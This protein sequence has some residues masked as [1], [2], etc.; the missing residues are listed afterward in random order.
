MKLPTKMEDH[1]HVRALSPI[2]IYFW[3]E[4]EQ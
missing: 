2:H 4:D 3:I 1:M